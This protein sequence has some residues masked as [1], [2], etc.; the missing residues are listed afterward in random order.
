MSCSTLAHGQQNPLLPHRPEQSC[1]SN[2]SGHPS[3]I[4]SSP[5]RPFG[6]GSHAL[7]ITAAGALGFLLV[8]CESGPESSTAGPNGSVLPSTLPEVSRDRGYYLDHEYVREAMAFGNQGFTSILAGRGDEAR[9]SFS[10]STKVLSNGLRTHNVYAAERAQSQSTAADILTVGLMLAGAA[11]AYNASTEATTTAQVDAIDQGLSN[12]LEGTASLGNFLQEQVRLGELNSAAVDG[13]DRDRWRSV[14]VSD[15]NFAR[16]IVRISNQTAGG[17]C[18]GF[19][20]APHVIMTAAHCFGAGDSLIAFRQRPQNG[21]AFMRGEDE[22]IEVQNAFWHD[23]WDDF[24]P[25]AKV[26]A[27]DVGFVVTR[28]PSTSYLPV[29]TRPIQPGQ[30][31]M[32]LGYSGDLNNGFF[33]QV[34]YGCSASSVDANGRIG[35]NCVTHGGNSGGPVITVDGGVAVVGVHSSGKRRHDRSADD[36]FGVPVQ[37]GADIFPSVQAHSSVAGLITTNPF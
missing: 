26:G 12:F 11:V 4:R 32:V 1:E 14:V 9:A 8:A 25:L 15:H 36:A 24:E 35:Y 20:I 6:P 37:R 17:Y 22:M 10:E 2:S 16:S 23:K 13:V 28:S 33:L 7:R 3:A 31:L 19:F 29:S 21:S 30:R 5:N 34:D 27:F 18:S